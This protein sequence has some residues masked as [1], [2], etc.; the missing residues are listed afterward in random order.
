M[1]TLTITSTHDSLQLR[2]DMKL[3]IRRLIN[4]LCCAISSRSSI[5]R[6]KGI[7]YPIEIQSEEKA[8][9]R[10]LRLP[11]A[12]EE[13]KLEVAGNDS[14]LTTGGAVVTQQQARSMRLDDA[15]WLPKDSLGFGKREPLP[16][17]DYASRFASG[18]RELIGLRL[19]TVY[20]RRLDTR[21]FQSEPFL[22]RDCRSH[23]S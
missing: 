19:V 2:I 9:T 14:A 22:E 3:I 12:G 10:D 20:R 5:H 11:P 6:P 23:C 16:D 18:A 8:P 1:L 17:A 7:E 21:A 13:N 4:H 15:N